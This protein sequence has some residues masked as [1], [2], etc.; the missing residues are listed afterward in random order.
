MMELF[1]PYLIALI[2]IGSCLLG[3]WM[4]RKTQ[5]KETMAMPTLKTSIRKAPIGEPEGDIYSEALGT[6]DQ[7]IE[8]I[9][10]L[11]SES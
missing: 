11:R 5:E 10:T 4:G 1:E 8:K 7:D 3:F 2:S 9:P 6:Q